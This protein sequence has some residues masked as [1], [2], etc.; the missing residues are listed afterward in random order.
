MLEYILFVPGFVL[1]VKGADFLIEGSS[2]LAKRFGVS[3]LIIGLTIVAFGTSLPEFAVNVLS[4][5]KGET[6]IA[7]GNVVGSN[8]ANILLVLGLS[9]MVFPF[10]IQ[11]STV[12]KEIPFNIFS[13]FV[14]FL[15]AINTI[16]R[17]EGMIMLLFFVIF[18]LY[19]FK[20]M[21]SDTER[22]R[23]KEEIKPQITVL[24]IIGGLMGI[25]LGGKWVVE[26]AVAIARALGVSEFMI[27]ITMVAFGTSLPE[28][29]T[30]LIAAIKKNSDL[31]VGNVIG[32]NVFNVFYV[33]GISALI[34]PIASPSFAETDLLFLIFV[35]FLLFIFMFIGEKNKLERWQGGTMVLLYV[36]YISYIVI[37]G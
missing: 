1:L 31:A 2:S 5:I 27:S 11:K 12:R 8:I 14:L 29:I 3:Q 21:K 19:T 15:M 9:T 36:L 28:L 4:A 25:F 18:M 17:A 32:S 16:T 22:V 30:S 26:G 35:S 20:T 6:E 33:L 13:A 37:R 34:T 23:I 7:L 24:M 10:P